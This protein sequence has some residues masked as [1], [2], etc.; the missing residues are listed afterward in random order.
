MLWFRE[1]EMETDQKILTR[2]FILAF[3]AQLAFMFIL[4]L[5]IPTLPL[6]LKKVGCTEI[7]I[8][9]LAGVFGI[10]SVLSRPLVGRVLVRVHEKTL[11]MVGAGLYTV[12]SVV[13][14]L[15]PPFWPFLFARIAHGASFGLF[16][17]ASTTHIVSISSEGNRTRVLSYFALAMNFAGVAAPPFGVFLVYRFGFDHLFIVCTGVSLC[18]LALSAALGRSPRTGSHGSGGYDGFL[19]SRQALPASLVG[20]T[21]LFT[22]SSVT[23]FFPIYAT[24]RGVTNPG[25]FFT[26]MAVMLIL[27]RTLGGRIMD[28]PNRGI[29]LIPCI[30]SSVAAMAILSISGTQGMFLLAA[31]VW[32]AGFAFLMPILL[33]LALESAGPSHSPVVATFY[34]ISDLGV[35]LG[36]LIMGAVVHYTNY[37]TMFLCLALMALAG[38]VYSFRF[39]RKERS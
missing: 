7:E 22:W 29:V 30:A 10:A 15:V 8:G 35:F 4:Q 5:L 2:E 28:I 1:P 21:I 3:C 33:T 13:Y 32:G 9:V 37:T 27:G 14:L 18:M 24:S 11:M 36:P 34:A 38:M 26:V 16:H 6:Y 31:A 20:F 12:C 25:L 39:A 17:T 23:T 19:L